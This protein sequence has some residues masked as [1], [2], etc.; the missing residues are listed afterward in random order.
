ML[1]KVRVK[2]KDI[3]LLEKFH[4]GYLMSEIH[5]L[6]SSIRRERVKIYVVNS[7]PEGGGVAE[8]LKSFIGYVKGLGI[9]ISWF[10]LPPDR[11]FFTITKNIH[12]GLQ[13]KVFEFDIKMRKYYLDYIYRVAED[14]L[15]AK[16]KPDIW[17][18]HDPQ[19]LPLVAFFPKSPPSVAHI[20]ID[21]TMPDKNVWRFIKG[22]LVMYNKV[23]FSTDMFV[24]PDL[25]ATFIEIFPPAIDP[26]TEKNSSMNL[27]TARKI[28]SSFG[29]DVTRPLI[30][31]VARFDP[32]KDPVGTI[33][34]YKLVKKEVPDVQLAILGLNIA[35]DDP[36][37]WNIYKLAV[38]EADGDKD[39]FLFF[40]PRTLGDL[41]V[42]MFVN[43]FLTCCYAVVHKSIREGFGLAVTEAM[44]KGKP[45]VAGNVGGLKVQIKNGENGFLVNSPE[46]AA[47]KLVFLLKNPTIAKRMGENA[48]ETVRKNFLIN[49]FIRDY[50]SVIKSTLSK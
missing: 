21:T 50:L 5:E 43:A 42:D 40:D 27:S 24:G 37:A 19:P 30:I 31:Q 11:K 26:M 10:V 38:E 7:T 48:R 3:Y 16:M 12:N 8:I 2:K 4:D 14:I 41:S 6:A 22:F 13:G 35:R 29:I 45:V 32:W 18:I 46:E 33:R 34:A 15:R 17:I 9:D 1:Q 28:V 49:R 20:H 25:P 23:I 39:I 47:E 36:E 44:W